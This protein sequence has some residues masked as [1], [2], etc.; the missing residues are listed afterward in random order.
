MATTYTRNLKLRLDSNLTANAKYNLERL[1][2]LGATFTVDTTDGLQLAAVTD[3]VIEPESSNIGGSGTGGTVS[4]GTPSH[5][6][7]SFNVYSNT[8]NLGNNLGLLDQASGGTN[9]LHIQYNSSLNGS[10]D[11]SADRNLSI[12]VDGA[13]RS[14]ILG[15]D[16]T[17]L[18]G[19]LILNLTGSTS[20]ILPQSGTLST[21]NGVETLTNKSMD[22][23]T[24]VITGLT[25]SSIS[26]SAG[27]SYSKLSL[28]GSL[29][30]SDIS[31]SAAIPYSK[32]SLTASIVDADISPTSNISRSKLAA[33]SPNQVVINDSS[34][35]Y[36]SSATLSPQLG[37]T[38]INS[39]AIF[40]SSGTIAT[41]SNSLT[42][43]NKSISGASNTLSNIAYSSLILTNSVMNADI[44]SSAGITYSKL[45][46]TG[47]IVNSDVS[48]SASISYSKLNLSG[49]IANADVS[50]SA[51]IAYSKLNLSSS[52]TNSDVSS[53]A[54]I[55]GTKISPAFGNQL[56]TTDMGI[57]FEI[58]GHQ[59]TLSGASSGQTTDL[60]FFL[61][62]SAGT[63]GQV[64]T[65]NGSGNTS[66]IDVAGT[67]TVTSIGV[68]APAEIT[69][70]GSPITT[71]GTIA[72]TWSNEAANLV[73]AGPTSGGSATPAF[74]SLVAADLNSIP[75][76]RRLSASWLNVDG[77]TKSIMHNWGSQKVTVEI[78]DNSNNY[79]TIEVS[80]VTRPD[81]NTVTLT[82]TEAPPSTWT[83]LITEVP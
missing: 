33:G 34:G 12:D 79:A 14:L 65:T 10:V 35:H 68:S 31:T 28:S 82:A 47:G 61:P 32:L 4:I 30:G 72:L 23:S 2:T 19:N 27:I 9:Y 6:I 11:T 69:V 46:L 25:N 66:W 29:L 22:G 64:L 39:S 73:F 49:S 36:S 74:R 43:S 58:G 20:I 37:G 57:G 76:Y 21:L 75:G 15:G 50:S 62:N 52:I 81:G 38:G 8:F 48:N 60:S 5:I 40:P 13:N 71:A 67:G 80:S 44:S 70:T 24:N 26:A 59:T 18:G 16:L 42:L 45:S 63:N 54:A 7:D 55:A 77:S 1:D 78:L 51:A 3:I 17:S 53:S 56:I 41:D 83:V